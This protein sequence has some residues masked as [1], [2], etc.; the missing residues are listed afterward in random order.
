MLRSVR[1]L[2]KIVNLDDE[3]KVSTLT[4]YTYKWIVHERQK[5]KHLRYAWVERHEPP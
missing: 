4:L 1:E 3:V 2:V 5:M